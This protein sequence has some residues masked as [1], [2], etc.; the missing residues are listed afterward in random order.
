MTEKQ[1]AIRHYL[2][3]NFYSDFV[4]LTDVGNSTVALRD[5]RGDEMLFG[6]NEYGDIIDVSDGTIYAVSGNDEPTE[7]IP[8]KW[9]NIPP[10]KSR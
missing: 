4:T 8:W 1:K 2:H 5:Y 3:Y 9:T 6:M 10:R 7:K